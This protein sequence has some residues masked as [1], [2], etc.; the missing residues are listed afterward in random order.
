MCIVNV[1]LCNTRIGRTYLGTPY[2]VLF[3]IHYPDLVKVSAGDS[4]E[5]VLVSNWDEYKLKKERDH[6]D[7]Q[8]LM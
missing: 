7:R 5:E 3:V 1:F 6:T 8:G 2:W 4:M